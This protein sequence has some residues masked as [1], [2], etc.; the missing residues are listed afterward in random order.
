[1]NKDNLPD[2]YKDGYSFFCGA[3]IDLSRRVLIP[4]P[5]TEFWARAAIIDLA[6]AGG[7]PAVLDIFSGSGCVGIAVARAIPGARVDL[8]DIDPAAIDQIGINLEINNISRGRARIY[9][10]DMFDVIPEGNFYNAILANPPYVDPGRLA[11]VQR[12]VLDWEPAR[13]LFSAKHGIEASQKFLCQ[14]R[15]RLADSGFIYLEFDPL[16]RQT[17]IKI[18]GKAG[19]SRTET[20]KDQ[21]GRWRFARISK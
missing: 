19:Y 1:M 12:S 13:A 3:K 4:R 21:Y 11:E 20:F 10:S 15:A 18:S 2:E 5:E 17:I 7:N 9:H 8:A 6:K 16:Q 14:A